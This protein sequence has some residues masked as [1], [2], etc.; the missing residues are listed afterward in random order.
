MAGRSFASTSPGRRD[1]YVEEIWRVDDQGRFLERIEQ[2]A[3]ALVKRD[4]CSVI[5][6]FTVG[7]DHE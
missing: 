5:E 3:G 6:F 7:A 2:T 1:I 4:E